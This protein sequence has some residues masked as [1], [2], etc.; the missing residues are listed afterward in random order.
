MCIWC[1]NAHHLQFRT[2]SKHFKNQE[3]SLWQE[4]RM[5]VKTVCTWLLALSCIKNIHDS[6][7]DVHTCVQE[8]HR[9]IHGEIHKCK[10]HGLKSNNHPAACA[11]YTS[12]KSP[13]DRSAYAPI[14][15]RSLSGKD[16]HFTKLNQMLNRPDAW[17][18]NGTAASSIGKLQQLLSS[19]ARCL[20]SVDALLPS[21]KWASTFHGKMSHFNTCCVV[22]SSMRKMRVD[23][24]KR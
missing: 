13:W 3:E 9:T 11:A 21:S 20:E 4:T 24:T 19:L 1:V 2:T 23:D 18:D 7:L 14:Q 15:P 6:L 16:L 12:G 17:D 8:H 5:K 22:C 10:L